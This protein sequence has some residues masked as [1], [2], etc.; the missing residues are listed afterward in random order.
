MEGGTSRLFNRI[1]HI[2]WFFFFAFKVQFVK[3]HCRKNIKTLIL[4]LHVRFQMSTHL[5][6]VI[7]YLQCKY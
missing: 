7:L 4:N 6:M 3:E 5:E 1:L 2:L